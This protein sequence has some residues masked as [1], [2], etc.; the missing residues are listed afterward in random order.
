MRI[1]APTISK[2]SDE[3]VCSFPVFTG[4]DARL[5]SYSVQSEY[6]S[7]LSPIADA[8]LVALLVPAMARGQDIHLETPASERL[9]KS[10]SGAAQSVLCAV[11]PKLKRVA[12]VAEGGFAPNHKRADGVA[13]GF[14]GGIDSYCT[15]ADYHYGNPAPSN[16]LTHL[17]FHCVGSATEGGANFAERYFRLSPITER[18]KLPFVSVHSNLHEFYSRELGF[19]Q[20]HTMRNASVPLLLQNGIGRFF[21]SATYPYQDVFVRPTHDIAHADPLLLPLLSTDALDLVSAGS[22]YDRVE[23]TLK[24]ADIADAWDSLDVCFR[25]NG[26]NC[27]NCAKCKRTMLTLDIAGKLDR[28][29][30]FDVA[31]YRKN[32]F[33]YFGAALRADADVF[34]RDVIEFAKREN[35]PIPRV[36]YVWARLSSAKYRLMRLV[37]PRSDGTAK[38]RETKDV[39]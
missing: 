18:T 3:F 1:G 15:L 22:E 19:Q 28:F 29:S 10:L 33:R 8:A 30:V 21:Y 20:T 31:H 5:L 4:R 34:F 17:T 36:S 16:R 11:M 6:E 14:S 39:P 25:T 13:T 27:S 35:Y 32:K 12:I 24:V 9:V 37:R 7:F 26:S 23:K 38:T 2:R